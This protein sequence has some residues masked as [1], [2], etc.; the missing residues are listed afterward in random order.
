M[1]P[2]LLCRSQING[3]KLRPNRLGAFNLRLAHIIN[4]QIA[5][6]EINTAWEAPGGVHRGAVTDT[7]LASLESALLHGG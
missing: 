5:K 3:Q 1:P 6:K 7:R 2:P 4:S